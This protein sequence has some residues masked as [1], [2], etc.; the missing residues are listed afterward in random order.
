MNYLK[1]KMN[2]QKFENSQKFK[3]KKTYPKA[4]AWTEYNPDNETTVNWPIEYGMWYAHE[5]TGELKKGY[6][7]SWIIRPKI[8]ASIEG[9]VNYTRDMYHIKKMIQEQDLKRYEKPETNI[10]RETNEENIARDWIKQNGIQIHRFA[11]SLCKRDPRNVRT[12]W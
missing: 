10:Q 12:R 9:K 4:I 8:M 6:I 1:R 2:S 3:Q 5:K 7:L 11:T